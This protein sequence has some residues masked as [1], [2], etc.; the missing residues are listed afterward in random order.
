MACSSAL[1]LHVC[2]A[3]PGG[4]YSCDKSRLARRGKITDVLFDTCC[5]TTLARYN[6]RAKSFDIGS[7]RPQTW[8][9]RGG[10]SSDEQQ[11]NAKRQN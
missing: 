9:C 1:P 11:G 6:I 4:H 3:F 5:Y 8:L 7:T 2:G 10:R